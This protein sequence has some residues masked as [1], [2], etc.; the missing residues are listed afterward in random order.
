MAEINVG[1]LIRPMYSFNDMSPTVVYDY[2][3]QK[4]V[5]SKT[6]KWQLMLVIGFMNEH[7]KQLRIRDL[8][9]SNDNEDWVIC[10]SENSEIHMLSL[11]QVQR[12]KS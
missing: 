1:S 3:A 2:C 10:L 6:K 9:A 8:S 5:H 12:L 11:T 4:Y 7:A